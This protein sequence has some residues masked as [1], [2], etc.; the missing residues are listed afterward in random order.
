[1]LAFEVDKIKLAISPIITPFCSF[2]FLKIN[3]LL[4]FQKQEKKLLWGK[5]LENNLLAPEKKAGENTFDHLDY[6]LVYPERLSLPIKMAK[7]WN[8]AEKGSLIVTIN[9]DLVADVW[10]RLTEM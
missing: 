6:L 7:H 1:M 2:L 4:N 10:L 9:Q 8:Y 3:R 5:N